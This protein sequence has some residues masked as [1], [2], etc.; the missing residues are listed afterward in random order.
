[1]PVRLPNY[2]AKIPCALFTLLFPDDCRL[3]NE[4][5]KEISRVP[6]C[7]SCLSLPVPLAADYF[8]VSCR[9]PFLNPAPL[10]EE[11]RCA[12]CRNGLRGFDAAYTFG[13]YE[14]TLRELVHLF[15][16]SRIRT[17]T[18]PLGDHLASAIPRDVQFDVVVPMPLH[19]LRRWRRGFNQSALLAKEIARRCGI[20]VMH[21]VSRTRSTL[22]QTGLTNAARRANVRGAFAVWR[23]RRVEGLRIL[24]VDDVMTTGATASACAL[25]LKRAGAKYVA[26]LTLARTDRRPA[27]PVVY[28]ERTAA[29]ALRGGA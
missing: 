7:R 11:G 3:C 9:T 18:K 21:A 4:P 1:M 17:L 20:P 26:L 5:L 12:L 29:A 6:I 13:A 24:L 2:S 28:A 10:D 14:G 23:R 15:K 16:Y 27:A 8:C 19:W 25:A 22:P